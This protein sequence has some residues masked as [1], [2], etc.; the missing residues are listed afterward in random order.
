MSLAE[1]VDD[2]SDPASMHC[3]TLAPLQHADWTAWQ[4]M[5]RPVP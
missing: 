1:R 2:F 4:A 3:A 5:E